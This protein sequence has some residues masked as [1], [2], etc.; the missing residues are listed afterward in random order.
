MR[1]K[2]LGE[3]TLSCFFSPSVKNQRFLPPPSSEGGFFYFLV[4]V[5]RENSTKM[6]KISNL[7]AS[8]PIIIVSLDRTL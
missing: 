8:I 5:L 6:G 4:Q 7:P 1:S 2:R 3:R